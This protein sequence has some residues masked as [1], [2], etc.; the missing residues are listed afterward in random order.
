MNGGQ[1]AEQTDAF[2][3]T[4][5]PGL[6]RPELLNRFSQTPVLIELHPEDLAKR[7]V[8]DSPL[9]GRLDL[10][11]YL[12]KHD[13]E[14][15]ACNLGVRRCIKCDPDENLFIVSYGDN[16]PKRLKTDV[17]FLDKIGGLPDKGLPRYFFNHG[18]GFESFSDGWCPTCYKGI[19][20]IE[21]F[22][23]YNITTA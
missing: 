22:K 16:N 12:H 11:S 23:R 14:L 2:Y 18:E 7:F 1:A 8:P 13:E 15:S 6:P 10:F 21:T 17:R 20:Q 5:L 19:R 9:K 4:E 3:E